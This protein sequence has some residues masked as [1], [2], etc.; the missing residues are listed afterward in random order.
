MNII[1]NRNRTTEESTCGTL[2]IE[3][4]KVCDTLESANLHLKTGTYSVTIIQCPMASRQ[5]PVILP[6]AEESSKIQVPSS[7]IQVPCS[8]CRKHLGKRENIRLHSYQVLEKAIKSGMPADELNQLEKTQDLKVKKR[9]AKY[10]MPRCPRFAV[11]NG[12]HGQTDAAILVGQLACRDT[13]IHSRETFLD[14]FDRLRK[15]LERGN[16]IQLTIQ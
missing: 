12:V 14:L 3:G 15:S 9:L 1:I 5:M 8:L 4:V 6:K 16:D 11:G 7:R 13:I 10:P 2:F